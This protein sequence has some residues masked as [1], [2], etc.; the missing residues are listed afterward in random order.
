MQDVGVLRRHARGVEQRRHGAV[1][2]GR[3]GCVG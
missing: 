1:R 3:C 2:Y